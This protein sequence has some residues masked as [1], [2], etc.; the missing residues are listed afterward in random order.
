MLAIDGR[1]GPVHDLRMGPA[2]AR[3]D[4]L[5]QQLMS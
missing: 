5:G 4:S 1:L 2:R 3:D